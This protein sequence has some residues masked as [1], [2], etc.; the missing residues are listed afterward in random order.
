MVPMLAARQVNEPISD[1][2]QIDSRSNWLFLSYDTAMERG[3]PILR[4]LFDVLRWH[5]YICFTAF[6]NR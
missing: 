2:A 1:A 5:A 6:V 4:Y 3:S